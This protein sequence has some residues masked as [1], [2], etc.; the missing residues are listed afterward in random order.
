MSRYARKVD[1]SQRLIIDCLTQAGCSVVA[2]QSPVAG[3]P[4]LLVGF[5]GRNYLVECKPVVTTRSGRSEAKNRL[6]ATQEAWAARW[7]GS[8]PFVVCTPTEAFELAS[9]WRARAA[10]DLEAAKALADRNAAIIAAY[11]E[12]T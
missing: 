1:S 9:T 10:K 4:D 3:L 11:E 2:I 6:R 5:L 12:S 7:R 8:K